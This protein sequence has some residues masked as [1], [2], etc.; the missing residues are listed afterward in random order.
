MNGREKQEKSGLISIGSFA[1]GIIDDAYLCESAWPC[2]PARCQESGLL[3][4]LPLERRF[5][6]MKILNAKIFNDDIAG[7]N[8]VR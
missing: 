5:Q 7:L 6:T 2:Q 8:E 3:G 1:R 4:G